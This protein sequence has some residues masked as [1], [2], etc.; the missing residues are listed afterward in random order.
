MAI[1]AQQ[2]ENMAARTRHWQQ[3]IFQAIAEQLPAG[4]RFDRAEV[5]AITAALSAVLVEHADLFLQWYEPRN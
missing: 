1:H 4:G 3:I 2:S 5:A